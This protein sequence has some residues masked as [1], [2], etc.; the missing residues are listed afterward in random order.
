MKRSA[1]LIIVLG[2]TVIILGLFSI[3]LSII[4]NQTRITEKKIRRIKSFYEAQGAIVHVF[5][6]LRREGT[7]ENVLADIN[8]EKPLGV[9]VT[10]TPRN[11]PNDPLCPCPVDAPSDFCVCASVSY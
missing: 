2:V 3:S 7:Q 6:R 10:V 11:T 8:N 1:V 9:N 4:I 5:E